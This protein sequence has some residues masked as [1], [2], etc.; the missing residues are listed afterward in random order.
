MQIRPDARAAFVRYR[1]EGD[2]KALAQVF[3]LVAQE[4]LLVACHLA[5]PAQQPEDLLHETFLTAIQRAD[6]YDASRPLEP[7]LVGILAN[8]TRNDRRRRA[9]MAGMPSDA[10]AQVVSDGLDPRD[11]AEQAEFMA[12]LRAAIG[13]L[14]LPQREVLTLHLV[15]GMTPTQI[16][17]ATARP[18]GTV[19]SWIHRSLDEVR[20]RMPAGLIGAFAAL[21]RG[22]AGVDGLRQRVLVET[23][24]DPAAPGPAQ[25]GPSQIGPSQIGPVGAGPSDAG[26]VTATGGRMVLRWGL[27]ALAALGAI[28]ALTMWRAGD[29]GDRLTPAVAGAERAAPPAAPPAA[30]ADRRERGA[31]TATV[32]SR[33]SEPSGVLAIT[34]SAEGEGD[35]AWSG[36]LVPNQLPDPQLRSIAFTTDA[37][38]AARFELP[39]GE[40]VIEPDRAENVAVVVRDGETVTAT[41][42]LA[43]GIDVAGRVVD[44]RGT[45]IAGAT[46]LL[47]KAGS[48]HEGFPATTTDASGEFAL[49]R[50]PP[51]RF[52]AAAAPGCRTSRLAEVPAEPLPNGRTLDL[53]LDL[54]GITTTFVVVDEQGLPVPGARVQVGDCLPPAP[55]TLAAMACRMRP[56]WTGTSDAAGRVVCTQA[57]SGYAEVYVRA[58]DR[59]GV[60]RGLDLVAGGESQFVLRRGARC[61]GVVR[62]TERV[63]VGGL[64]AAIGGGFT[65]APTTPTWCL[66]RCLID[67]AGRYLLT[68]VPVG[69]VL[70]RVDVGEVGWADAD[71][72]I[73]DGQ[74]IEWSPTLGHGRS[75]S[76]RATVADGTPLAGYLVEARSFATRPVRAT[77]AADGRFVLEGLG[78]Q[79]CDVALRPPK[80]SGYAP[81]LRLLGVRPAATELAL[82]VPI[83]KAPT[84]RL[85]GRLVDAPV[86][87]VG[88]LQAG[89]G[90]EFGGAVGA[91]G[92]FEVVGVPPGRYHLFTQGNDRWTAWRDVTLAANEVADLGAIVADQLATLRIELGEGTAAEQVAVSS[93]DGAAIVGFAM[94]RGGSAEC[95]V[96]FGTWRVTISGGGE[97][98]AQ[99]LVRVTSP[100]VDVPIQVPTTMVRIA[101]RPA[102]PAIELTVLWT[103]TGADGSLVTRTARGRG[104]R[105]DR[106][107]RLHAHIAPGHYT[108]RAEATHGAA[109]NGE[110]D[111]PAAGQPP[112]LT[113]TLEGPP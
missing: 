97:V 77:T 104:A 51:G 92:G 43:R 80:T 63:P 31:A 70:V 60:Q 19:K 36:N 38:G 18:I 30:D 108:V 24:A 50:L 57:P 9:R 62:A 58:A 91:D 5:G 83:A 73:D 96:P 111:V 81:L 100:A 99:R 1:D 47:T 37:S 4:L 84:A 13:G 78:S 71:L 74:D 26:A 107:A 6:R 61:H 59:V 102:R 87:W 64:V 76:G 8:V 14:P 53:H 52:L 98:L 35:L 113:L 11:A 110:L 95:A 112:L 12:H 94:V 109:A 20:R 7:W 85:R 25:A 54:A 2:P 33:E 48:L 17:H 101:A 103:I 67:G 72:R 32:A 42:R 41:I 40:F 16:G 45:G 28:A 75:Q 82:T 23:G 86:R 39:P 105:P 27:A 68:G 89:T 21:L 90:E 93:E 55:Q 69:E 44:G 106:E 34:T 22:M 15:H 29:R 79:V 49:R 88:L 56:P 10:D 46:V 3:D 66:P 65:A